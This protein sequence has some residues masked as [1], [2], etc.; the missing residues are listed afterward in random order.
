MTDGFDNQFRL[1]DM[2]F[3]AAIERVTQVLKT[4]G[5]GVLCT[6]D[7]AST[8]KSRLGVEMRPYVNLGA[9]NPHMAQKALGIDPRSGVYLP[10]NIVLR[11]VDGGVEVNPVDPM[12]TLGS[13]EGLRGVAEQVKGMLQDILKEL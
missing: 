9:C 3:P 8:L 12:V 4:H 13:K 6:T 7:I 1:L 10:C 11:E 5:F 2:P